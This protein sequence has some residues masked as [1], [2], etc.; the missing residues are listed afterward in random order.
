MT[1]LNIPKA[2]VGLRLGRI[3]SKG[4]L[5]LCEPVQF[6]DGWS[7]VETTLRRATISGRVE[8][9]GEINNHFADVMDVNGD[10]VETVSLDRRSYAALKN[11]WMRCKVQRTA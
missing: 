2:A 5:K 9:G 7:A 3:D 4:E 11:H 10:I 8:T 1:T 6:V